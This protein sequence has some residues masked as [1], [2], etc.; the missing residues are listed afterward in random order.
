MEKKIK[1]LIAE[2][3]EGNMS[4]DELETKLLVLYRVT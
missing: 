1:Q 2:F 4:L 3:D